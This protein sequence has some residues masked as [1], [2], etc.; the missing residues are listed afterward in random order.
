MSYGDPAK[1]WNP[2]VLTEEQGRPLIRAAIE[3]GVNFFD[4]ANIYSN[5]ASEE[6]LGRAIRDFARR[7]E[8]VIATK[9]SGPMHKGVNALGLSRKSILAEVDQSLRRLGTDYIDLYQIHSWDPNTPIEETLEAL[10]DVVR[11]GKV[12]YLGASNTAA[13][14]FC[15]A[16]YVAAGRGWS[17][18]VSVQ[19]HLNLLYREEEREMLPLCADQGIGVIPWSP[20][21]R[22]LLARPWSDD[23]T[24]ERSKTDVFGKSLYDRAKDAD[25][26]VVDA[27]GE[28]SERIGAPR[29]EIALAWLFAKREVSAPIVGVTKPAHLESALKA[30]DLTLD[31][32][33]ITALDERYVPH[34]QLSM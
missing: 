9:V 34:Q 17:R 28:L 25:R 1:G 26:A 27:V 32:E 13:W 18:F 30:L 8:V 23:P 19:V 11:A 4:T 16:L 22:G 10:D 29:S 12:R 33:A 7:D 2:W 14:Q 15:Q 24:T 20:L 5:G 21:A 31:A 6:V 3:A